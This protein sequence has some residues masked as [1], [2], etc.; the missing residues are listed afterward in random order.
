[1]NQNQCCGSGPGSDP[2]SIVSVDP[3]PGAKKVEKKE[4]VATSEDEKSAR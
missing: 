3:D 2:D 1:M 4:T